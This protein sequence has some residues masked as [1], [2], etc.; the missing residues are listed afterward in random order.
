MGD[1]LTT[2]NLPMFRVVLLRFGASS[3]KNKL[4][5]SAT[6]DRVNVQVCCTT[7]SN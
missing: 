2:A 1:L 4:T 3:M 6:L 5:V 7:W